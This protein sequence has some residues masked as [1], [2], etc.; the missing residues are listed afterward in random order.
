MKPLNPISIPAIQPETPQMPFWVVSPIFRK[1]GTLSMNLPLPRQT[2][3]AS[4]PQL[5]APATAEDR[6][7][8]NAILE[9][10]TKT[11][12]NQE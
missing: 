2:I 7:T 5:Q 12:N 9:I 6:A 1:S 4:K 8:R 3:K 11:V 10:G